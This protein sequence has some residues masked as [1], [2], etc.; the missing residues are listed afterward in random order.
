MSK[1]SKVVAG[2]IIVVVLIV[3]IAISGGK[4]S[5]KTV[6][7]GEIVA[8][9]G[10]FA[11]NGEEVRN[12][13]NLAVNEINNTGGILGKNIE[14]II[15]DGKC[16]A[17]TAVSA[18]NKLIS[19]DKVEFVLGGN[20]STESAAIAPLSVK[21]KVLALANLTTLNNIPNEGEWFFR[22]SPP[23][24]Y[25]STIAANYIVN[26]LKYKKIGVIS[27]IKEF[28]KNYAE[29]FVN[30]AK[31]SGA[32]IV[33]NEEFSPGTT[34]F[35]SII[36]KIK[37]Q[38]V[39]IILL[40]TQSAETSGIIAKQLS[41]LGIEKPQ[42]YSA[43]FTLGLFLKG[44]GGYKPTKMI[45]VNSYADRDQPKM[46]KYINDYKTAYNS[47][48]AF[49]DYY[50]SATYDMVYRL[51]SAMESCKSTTDVECIR[52]QF[53]NAQSYEGVS[54]NIQISSQYSPKSTIVPQGLLVIDEANKTTMKAIGK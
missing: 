54:G 49:N 43:S 28:P 35:R 10:G 47:D 4:S 12:S 42:T 15:E 32:N 8:L 19:I 34:D 22:N 3:A 24:S 40:S 11:K 25:V 48:I 17:P 39:D 18:W 5:G 52:N 1:N 14:L 27:E 46:A 31:S 21:A 6:K 9:T 33:F 44:T 30:T 23:A 26:D 50:I 20:C 41:E 16:D 45:V 38:N 37:N 53:K 7:I 51:K 29:F 13:I 36:S 2:I